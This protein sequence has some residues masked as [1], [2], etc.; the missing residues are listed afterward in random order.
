MP[1]ELVALE[2]GKPVLREYE[3]GPVPEGHIRVKVEFGAPKHGTELT[4]Y[5]GL[6][7]ARFPMGL[8]NMCVG[9]VVELGEGVGDLSIGDRV[10]GYGHLRE[11]HTW[12]ADGVWK[13]S[14]RMT[15]KEA[16][17]FDPAQFALAGVRDGQVRLGD[18]VAVFGLGAIGQM[19][20]QMARAA[21]AIFVAA[22]DPI[23]LRRE[24]ALQNG[25]D[26][27][28]DPTSQNVGEELKRAT[29]GRGVDVV[30]ETSGNY[31]AL[32]HAFRGLAFGGNVAYVGWSK[33]CKGGLD[34]GEVAHFTI[35][36][37]IFARACS[38]PNRDHPRWSFARIMD[39]CWEMLAEGHFNCEDV[40][41][42]VVPFSESA[43][44]Y[45]EFVEL[46]PERSVK[47]GVT[48]D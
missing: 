26:M 39:T 30:I 12:R 35:P 32:N 3:D 31:E 5:H 6:R 44:A 45:K 18:C 9:R 23:E 40:V 41:Q 33:E 1:K 19:A 21:G 42:P 20:V 46:H 27:V 36:N 37:L 43:E 47:L 14:E 8:G 48:F 29:G 17:C 7:G 11:T 25:A 28:L 24:V 4:L 34:F 10:A 15:W 16:V 13:L 22:V 2:P 38:D